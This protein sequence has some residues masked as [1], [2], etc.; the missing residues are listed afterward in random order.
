M[1]HFMEKVKPEFKLELKTKDVHIH[2]VYN[3]QYQS[4]QPFK[5]LGT[6]DPESN[7]QLKYQGTHCPAKEIQVLKEPSLDLLINFKTNMF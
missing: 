2:Y 4:R 5:S 1:H 7:R 6:K 3:N